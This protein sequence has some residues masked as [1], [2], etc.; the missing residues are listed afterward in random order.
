MFL[1]SSNPVLL[2]AAP[3]GGLVDAE[4][5]GSLLKRFCGS[6]HPPD[7]FFFDFLQRDRIAKS[8]AGIT[9][10]QILRKTFNTHT[11]GLTENS[12]PFNDISQF[13][14]VSRPMVLSEGLKRLWSETEEEMMP[15]PAKECQQSL[16]KYALYLPAVHAK[17]GF[18]SES[19]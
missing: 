2:P 14:E 12:C 16:S 13:S 7:M 9:G 11:V 8:C 6:Q 1:L 10:Q 3:Q 15:G 19:H 17:E 5:I 18:R 4:D